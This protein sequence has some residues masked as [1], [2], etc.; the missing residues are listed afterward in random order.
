VTVDPDQDA[1]L[2]RLRA[3]FGY[4]Q[5]MAIIEHDQT[6]RAPTPDEVAEVDQPPPR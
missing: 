2:R 4:V 3:A 5:I 1:A 6:Q